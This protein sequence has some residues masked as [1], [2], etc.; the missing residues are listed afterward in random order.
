MKKMEFT[1]DSRP[2]REWGWLVILELFFTPAG[3]GTFVFALILGSSL[4]MFIGVVLVLLGSF[5]LLADL[6][7]PLNAWRV[8]TRPQTS[9]ISRGAVGIGVFLVLSIFHIIALSLLHGKWMSAT[10]V[11]WTTGPVWLM[12]LGVVAGFSALFV[13]VYPGFLLADMHS[14]PFWNTSLLPVL[15]LISGLFSGIGI[16]YVIPYPWEVQIWAWR[17]LKALSIGVYILGCLFV[18]V[19][20]L[21]VSKEKRQEPLNHF[22]LD[23]LRIHFLGGIIGVGV[24]VPFV[25]LILLFRGWISGA[26]L[27]LIGIAIVFGM[28]LLRY[29][30]LR[31]GL[32]RKPV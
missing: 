3:A 7:K 4:H 8:I 1:I 5:L 29:C 15:F 19:L 31:G 11:P 12:I 10:G 28:L 20:T 32:H 16:V 22:S 23:K 21:M 9:W 27:P 14:I 24:V 18:F 13:A 26:L 2:Q 17:I 6:T 30:L 25:L